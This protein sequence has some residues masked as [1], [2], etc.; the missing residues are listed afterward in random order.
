[1]QYQTSE[2][3]PE[4]MVKGSYKIEYAP[5]VADH[6]TAVWV[7]VGMCDDPVFQEEITPLE[8]SPSNGV[9]PKINTGVAQQKITLTFAPWALEPDNYIALRGDIDKKVTDVDGNVTIFSGGGCQQSSMM[10]RFSNRRCDNATAADVAQY[11]NESLTVGDEIT[12]EVR[13]I[14][15]KCNT[16]GGA[17]ITGKRDD[18]TDAAQRFPWTM[19]GIHDE[20]R[21]E[22]EQVW[23]IEYLVTKNA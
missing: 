16:T 23:A 4:Y 11:P 1:M 12:R 15:F 9:K 19:E 3:Y 13:F 2:L 18:D 10:M 6:T 21:A 5:I 7:D 20:T 8:G 17:N 14:A 22:K